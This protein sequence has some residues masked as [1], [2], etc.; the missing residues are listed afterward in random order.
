MQKPTIPSNISDEAQGFLRCT[1]E[2]EQEMR[3][4]ATEL[5]SHA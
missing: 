5:L 3:P 2:T 4:S 1:F